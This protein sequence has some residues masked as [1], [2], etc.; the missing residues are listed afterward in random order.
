MSAPPHSL[1]FSPSIQQS[2]NQ[3]IKRNSLG[4]NQLPLPSG[5]NA[6]MSQRTLGMA[7]SAAGPS[8][9]RALSSARPLE[10]SQPHSSPI[11]ATFSLP[12]SPPPVHSSTHAGGIQP[13]AAF[14]RPVRPNYQAHYSRP[15]SPESMNAPP[16]DNFQLAPIANHYDV[17]DH[18][19][20]ES[21]A[22]GHESEQEQQFM[23]LKRMKQSREPLLP[24]PHGIPPSRPSMNVSNS[25]TTTR[26]VRNSLDRVM[27]ISRGI[28]FDSIRKSNTVRS[29]DGR[30]TFDT[31]L[32][33]E[34]NG[35]SPTTYKSQAASFEPH[36]ARDSAILTGPSPSPDP[37][38]VPIPPRRRPPLSAVPL[39][40]PQAGKVVQRYQVH[41]SRNRF[42][43]RGRLLTGGDTPWAFIGTLGLIFTIG[44]VWLGTTAVWWWNHKSPAVAAVGIYLALLILSTM[45]ATVSLFQHCTLRIDPHTDLFLHRRRQI[46]EFC[47]AIWTLIRLTHRHLL[48]MVAIV[49]LCPV[50]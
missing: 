32:V 43:L 20:A 29:P 6:P 7:S 46:Q 38:F 13:A 30:P 25:S 47:P 36:N 45:L 34:E 24:G 16:G 9:P 27:S 19:M 40:D 15:S 35:Y 18:H 44:G 28:S 42:F 21:I 33:D 17:D 1:T 41:P 26:L 23:T 8:S 5:L 39:V 37:S 14:F 12:S 11:L 49:P 2:L 10:T 3:N 50:I 22:G 31:K 48:P 4:S